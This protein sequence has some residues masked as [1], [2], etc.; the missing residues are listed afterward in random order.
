MGCD[1][2]EYEARWAEFLVHAS[3]NQTRPAI[4]DSDA[5]LQFYIYRVAVPTVCAFGILGNALN[6]VV[7]LQ[8]QI[9]RSMDYMEKSAH[10]GIVALALSDMLF[11]I[12]GFPAAFI[13]QD[14]KIYVGSQSLFLFYYK[15]YQPPL[16]NIFM[17][18]STWLVVVMAGA[19]YL[20]ICWPLHARSYINLKA[21]FVSILLVFVFSTV[22]H[23]PE[24]WKTPTS[25][26]ECPLDPVC[27]CYM[28]APATSVFYTN[29]GL[30]TSYL[31][32]RGIITTAIPLIVLA[33]CNINLIRALHQSSKMQR[34]YRA[35]APKESSHRITLTLITM[36][37]LFF[38]L[39][40]PSAILIFFK[41]IGMQPHES[42][43]QQ[44]AT[45]Q[46]VTHILNLLQTINFSI[47]FILYCLINVHF[48]KV[49]VQIVCFKWTKKLRTSRRN[50][51][52]NGQ[53]D[54][55][56][57]TQTDCLNIEDMDTHTELDNL[58]QPGR[59]DN[60]R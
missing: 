47:N 11:C 13:D 44:Y 29:E 35:N 50:T 21:T 45:Y 34:K 4:D 23:L 19:R 9:R 22:L 10:M 24:F 41:D 48:R 31:I 30:K 12:V 46:T 56:M 55:S 14:K 49:M 1:A 57:I 15:S 28:Y 17:V 16:I 37:V 40:T 54:N 51:L 8:H 26:H 36:V 32:F 59:C 43:Y 52:G 7:L 38:I 18:S 6:L 39:V 53:G 3:K 58:R 5:V 20:A 2:E 60:R 33:F 42:N 27:T 25:T